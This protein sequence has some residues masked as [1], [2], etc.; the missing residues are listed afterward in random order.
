[1]LLDNDRV[2]VI[3]YR[4]APGDKTPMHSHPD[5]VPYA[6]GDAK[7]RFTYPKGKPV[8]ATSKAGQVTWHAA[9]THAGQVTGN[10]EAHILT[11][12]VK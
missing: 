11:V 8:E 3:E 5:Y 6:L 12:E 10:N 7:T 4:A 2:R 9:E 1:M